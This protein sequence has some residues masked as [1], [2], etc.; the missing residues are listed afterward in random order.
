MM[1]HHMLSVARRATPPSGASLAPAAPRPENAKRAEPAPSPAAGP[2]TTYG[3]ASALAATAMTDA[4]AGAQVA[5]PTAL[6]AY[7]EFTE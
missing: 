4:K 5:L 3:P 1:I 6:A 2:V 7:Q